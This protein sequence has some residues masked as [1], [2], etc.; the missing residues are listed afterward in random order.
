MEVY[1]KKK[2]TTDQT[3]SISEKDIKRAKES[4]NPVLLADNIYKTW[5]EFQRA[6]D[7]SSLANAL[8][9]TLCLVLLEET[10]ILGKGSFFK[11][12]AGPSTSAYGLIGLIA[13]GIQTAASTFL[14]LFGE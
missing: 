7:D 6:N 8:L 11:N 4:G 9:D 10:D 14:S 12:S 3:C 5:S 2:S 1:F 13:E